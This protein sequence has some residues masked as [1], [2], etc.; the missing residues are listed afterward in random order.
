V[1]I[2]LAPFSKGG[3]RLQNVDYKNDDSDPLVY[4]IKK[5]GIRVV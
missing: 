4:E 3:T 1:E 2:P 5:T